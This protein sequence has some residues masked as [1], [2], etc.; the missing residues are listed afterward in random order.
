MTK[1]HT[2]I[3]TQE[4]QIMSLHSMKQVAASLQ[5]MRLNKRQYFAQTKG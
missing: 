1:H 4:E 5:H 3:D 2:P